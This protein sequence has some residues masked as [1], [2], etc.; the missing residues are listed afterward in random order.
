MVARTKKS[1]ACPVGQV[2]D[3]RNKKTYGYQV[4]SRVLGAL[5]NFVYTPPPPHN[6]IALWL[7]VPLEEPP[8]LSLSVAVVFPSGSAW[9]SFLTCSAEGVRGGG[10]GEALYL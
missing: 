10:G 6:S 8:R 9:V 4:A 7:S 5:T 2:Q 3:L 1:G